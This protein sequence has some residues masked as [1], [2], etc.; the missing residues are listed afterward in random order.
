MTPVDI[1]TARA[2]I[3]AAVDRARAAGCLIHKHLSFVEYTPNGTRCCALGAFTPH[4]IGEYYCDVAREHLGWSIR[5]S[6]SFAQG[7]DRGARRS[8]DP[9]YYALG[10]EIA[11]YLFGSGEEKGR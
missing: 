8:F 7:F 10:Q 9:E 3:I 4:A 11:A 6:E 5:Q 1:P 2:A